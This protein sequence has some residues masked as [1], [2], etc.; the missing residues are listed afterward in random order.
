MTKKK[1]HLRS[2]EVAVVDVVADV[3]EPKMSGTV[4]GKVKCIFCQTCTVYL[5]FLYAALSRSHKV[6]HSA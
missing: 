1:Y 2:M 3:A 4:A 5:D 6:Y